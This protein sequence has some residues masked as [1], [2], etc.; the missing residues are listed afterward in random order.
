MS[1]VLCSRRRRWCTRGID[2]P[3]LARGMFQSYIHRNRLF[4]MLSE[5]ETQIKPICDKFLPL[6]V[7]RA[8]SSLSSFMWIDGA[9]EMGDRQV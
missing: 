2:S 5:D 3:K 4:A 9:V 8:S 7:V 1:G 6:E